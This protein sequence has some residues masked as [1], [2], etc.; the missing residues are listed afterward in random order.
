MY[1][2]IHT[3]LSLLNLPDAKFISFL[4]TNTIVAPFLLLHRYFFRVSVSSA[5]DLHRVIAVTLL[6]PNRRAASTTNSGYLFSVKDSPPKPFALLASHRFRRPLSPELHF[7]LLNLK[8]TL[9]IGTASPDVLLFHTSQIPPAEIYPR[10]NF[11]NSRT[12][13]S[14]RHHYIPRSP[15]TPRGGI[16]SSL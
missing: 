11:R 16:D 2:S 14:N 7:H 9:T 5:G 1:S 8:F 4:Y 12:R 10:L 13:P 15:T 6:L 3:F